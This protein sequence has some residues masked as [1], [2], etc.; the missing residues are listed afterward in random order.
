MIL[1]NRQFVLVVFFWTGP[2]GAIV[3]IRNAIVSPWQGGLSMLMAEQSPT[4]VR[5]LSDE[6]YQTAALEEFPQTDVVLLGS[7]G[8]ANAKV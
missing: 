1:R 5:R 8:D 2:E 4:T 6:E 7:E 3:D